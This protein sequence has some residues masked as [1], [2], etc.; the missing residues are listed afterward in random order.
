MK[1]GHPRSVSHNFFPL[2]FLEGFP[3]SK[4]EC[5]NAEQVCRSKIVLTNHPHSK[6]M[7][8]DNSEIVVS[9]VVK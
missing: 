3:T 2:G 7:Q 4:S 6:G 1:T 5:W 9:K 8:I